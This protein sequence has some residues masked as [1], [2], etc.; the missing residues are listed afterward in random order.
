M[1]DIPSSVTGSAR[2]AAWESWLGAVAVV[3]GVLL[4]ATH[5]TEWMRQHVITTAAPA[6]GELPQ[7]EC[8]ED[9]LIAGGLSV[10]EGEQLVGTVRSYL[11][12]APAW[13]PT[14]M[15]RLAAA[16]TVLALAS[17]VV[18]AALVDHR[19][20]ASAASI[21]VFG[22]LAAIDA[23]GFM[24]AVNTGP[25]LRA[26]YLWNILLWFFVHLMMT[27]GAAAGRSGGADRDVGR[28]DGT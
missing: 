8:P 15:T 21:P 12:S 4:A 28:N 6:H 19:A 11:A 27:V 9:E 17:V 3:L 1:P 20:W 23:V 18:G 26:L 14:L 25:L 24:G 5:G 10:A 7:A 13:F 16:G 2:G 22:G